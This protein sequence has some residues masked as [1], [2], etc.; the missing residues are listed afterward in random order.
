M[1]TKLKWTFQTLMYEQWVLLSLLIS[2]GGKQLT[3]PTLEPHRCVSGK[4]KL[5]TISLLVCDCQP[6]F[7]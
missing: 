3:C 2:R 1:R 7:N 4:S 5:R 6:P